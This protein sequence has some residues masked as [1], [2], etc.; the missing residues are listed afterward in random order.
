MVD[1]L[2]ATRLE[3]DNQRHF[4]AEGKNI[5]TVRDQLHRWTVGREQVAPEVAVMKSANSMRRAANS[6]LFEVG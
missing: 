2:R 3:L 1:D 6:G 5:E 4:T